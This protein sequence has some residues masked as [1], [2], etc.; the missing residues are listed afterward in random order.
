MFGGLYG[1]AMII[2][3]IVYYFTHVRGEMQCP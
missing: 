2:A 3:S 1:I